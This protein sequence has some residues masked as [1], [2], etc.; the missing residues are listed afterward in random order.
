MDRFSLIELDERPDA[1]AQDA[2]AAVR[3]IELDAAPVAAP[4]FVPAVPAAPMTDAEARASGAHGL[5][6]SGAAEDSRRE[7][8]DK[9]DA[10]LQRQGY[11][12]E[13]TLFRSGYAVNGTTDKGK[14]GRR[15]SFEAQ[16]LAIPALRDAYR[17]VAAERRQ[18][19]TVT[20]SALRMDGGLL[21]ADGQALAVEEGAMGAL[22]SALVGGP[23][24]RAGAMARQLSELGRIADRDALFDILRRGAGNDPILVRTRVSRPS[25]PRSV[26]AV[27]S[28]TY[29][30][31]LSTLKVIETVGRALVDARLDDA[32]AMV[33]YDGTSFRARVA[34]F[35]G[36]S[37]PSVGDTFQT[38][39]Q[40]STRDDA[41]RGNGSTSACAR[42]AGFILRNLCVNYGIVSTGALNLGAIIHR[43]S[44]NDAESKAL[45][46]ARNAIYRSVNGVEALRNV[47]IVAARDKV[48]GASN[49]APTVFGKLIDDGL[50][51]V[52]VGYDGMTFREA[53][54]DAYLTTPGNS[55]TA[56]INA[57]TLTAQKLVSPWAQETLETE[58]GALLH[59][60]LS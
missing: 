21:V 25:L 48:I 43:K 11:A 18:D 46:A 34:L 28:G 40:V 35:N 47:W 54:M 39:F 17:T 53:L 20:P 38:G 29:A 7:Y 44:K 49:D 33:D 32:R 51:S 27:V 22:F 1:P 41:G 60:R 2:P 6:S 52:P 36:F 15:L 4:V 50:V 3:P 24:T 19:V 10:E 5:A 31:D 8:N 16:P 13:R 30:D 9:V 14:A 26:Y 42:F 55:K 12:V 45:S 57:L 59:V 56:V 37:D 58:A 23:V